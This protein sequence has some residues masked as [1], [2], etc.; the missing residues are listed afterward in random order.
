MTV[1]LFPAQTEFRR[2]YQQLGKGYLTT[3]K[4]V[5][6]NMTKWDSAIE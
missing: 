4:S 3:D 5:K 1:N 2:Y 6:K